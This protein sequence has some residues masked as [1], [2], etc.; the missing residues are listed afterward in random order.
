MG[1][2]VVTGHRYLSG[3][4]GDL[5]DRDVFVHH[6]VNKWVNYVNMFSD[7]VLIQCQLAYTAVTRPLQHEWTFLLQVLPDCGLLFRDLESSLAS[8]F[9]PALFGVEVSS[10]ES[11][12]FSLPL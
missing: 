2:Q 9:L 11:N 10:V 3:F 8:N 5:H 1:V 6:K 7:I 12:L 4:I